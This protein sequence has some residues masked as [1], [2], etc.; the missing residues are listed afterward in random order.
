MISE[1]PITEYLNSL[2][3]QKAILLKRIQEVCRHNF[4]SRLKETMLFNAPTYWID[5]QKRFS[6]IVK[7]HVIIFYFFN[8]CTAREYYSPNKELQK[9]R[10]SIPLNNS[11]KIR[12]EKLLSLIT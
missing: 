11:T 2:P 3:D 7:Q 9:N 12:I 1:T 10:V 5:N 6:V 8:C 4:G